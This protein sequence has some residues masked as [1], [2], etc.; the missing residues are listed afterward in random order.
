[1]K[2]HDFSTEK[3]QQ[4]RISFGDHL[5]IDFE[6]MNQSGVLKYDDREARISFICWVTQTMPQ[7][8]LHLAMAVERLP[9]V[10]PGL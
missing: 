3:Q 6:K 5:L 8:K 1:M 2:P 4:L 10:I 7:A 9:L